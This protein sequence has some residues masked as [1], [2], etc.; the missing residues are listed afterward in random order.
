MTTTT[1]LHTTDALVERLFTAV[2]ATLD[3]QSV[4]LG[5]RLGW[6]R[7]LE[8]SGEA[9]L[10]RACLPHRDRRALRPRVAGAAGRHRHPDR[11]RRHRREHATVHPP[12]RARRTADRR[13]QPQPP[14]ARWRASSSARA[15]GSTRWPR[16]TDRRRR[17]LGRTRRRRPRGPGRGQPAAVPRRARPRVLPRDPRRRRRPA[18]G[19]PD[20]R[21]RLRAGLVVHRGGAGLPRGAGR[22]LRRR[23][24]VDR[25]GAAQR[26]RGRRGRP[27]AVPPDRRGGDRR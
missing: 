7:A 26:G 27:G 4:Y 6:Y 18:R 10:D 5:D 19:R 8:G 16:P 2:L 12:R 22:R 20:G 24:T 23:R 21:H 14:R 17:Q 13:A 11:E 25:G 1:P 15:S 9:H 3:V